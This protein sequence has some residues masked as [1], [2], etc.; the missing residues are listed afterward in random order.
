MDS[1]TIESVTK[2]GTKHKVIYCCKWEQIFTAVVAM[3][4]FI[5]HVHS[6]SKRLFVFAFEALIKMLCC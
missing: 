1:I 2:Q 4:C 6:G 5:C 3:P